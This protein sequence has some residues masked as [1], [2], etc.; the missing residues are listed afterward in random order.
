M[1][2]Y[3]YIQNYNY[4]NSFKEKGNTVVCMELFCQKLY[5]YSNNKHGWEL[6]TKLCRLMIRVIS[7]HLYLEVVKSEE[8]G[9]VYPITHVWT[10]IRDRLPVSGLAFQPMSV[11]FDFELAAINGLGNVVQQ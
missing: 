10:T 5:G 8:R 1:N 2:V 9:C 11:N 4:N 6:G 7:M 3:K